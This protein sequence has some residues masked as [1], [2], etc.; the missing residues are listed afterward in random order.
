LKAVHRLRVYE[1]RVLRQIFEPNKGEVTGDRR[2]LHTEGLHD[3]YFSPN[4]F[5]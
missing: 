3:F 2:K 4:N 1:N 5:R